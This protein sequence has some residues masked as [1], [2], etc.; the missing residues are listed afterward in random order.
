M[1]PEEKPTNSPGAL[2][3]WGR[4]QRDLSLEEVARE[5]HLTKERVVAIEENDFSSFS[6]DTFVRGYLRLFARVIGIDEK[7]VV[8]L[9]DPDLLSQNQTHQRLVRPVVRH[10]GMNH[11]G[12]KLATWVIVFV[13]IGLL[14]IWWFDRDNGLDDRIPLNRDGSTRMAES[15]EGATDLAELVTPSPEPEL[16]EV[17]ASAVIAKAPVS[18]PEPSLNRT[19]TAPVIASVPPVLSVDEVKVVVKEGETEKT[20]ERVVVTT[21]LVRSESTQKQPPSETE[22]TVEVKH[23]GEAPALPLEDA[24]Q[25]IEQNK[26]QPK[27]NRERELEKA[28]EAKKPPEVKQSVE[29]KKSPPTR[30]PEI[31]RV[32]EPTITP[33]EVDQPE[34]TPAK[35]ERSK[36]STPQPA[37]VS[38]D[39][40]LVFVDG[41]WAAVRDATGEKLLYKFVTQG[42][43]I[44]LSGTPPYNVFLGNAA[45][46]KIDF[47]GKPVVVIPD[48]TGLYSRFEVGG[49][50]D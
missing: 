10:V 15:V 1:N 44:T 14:A 13:F 38:D 8:D 49:G 22:I 5:L 47:R 7:E 21:E 35:S 16:T 48:P 6:G 50:S 12:L 46:V 45:G 3:R 24:K 18:D 17:E 25:E 40:N 32:E 26:D 34:K 36:K 42:Q 2:L 28:P 41:S 31:K 20:Q 29:A 19:E 27:A 23:G 37:K 39:L 11:T 30:K 43:S 33:K 9:L 4:E